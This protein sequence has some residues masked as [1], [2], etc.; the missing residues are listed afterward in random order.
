MTLAAIVRQSRDKLIAGDILVSNFNNAPTAAASGGEQGTG[1]PATTT[2]GTVVRLALDLDGRVPRLVSS[3]VIADGLS[4]HTDPAALIVGPTGLALDH[5]GDL[6]VADTVNSRIAV[7]PDAPFRRTPINAGADRA[8]VSHDPALNG[9][10]GLAIAPDGHLLAVNG[11]DNNVVELSRS[12]TAVT[13]RDLDPV[14]PPGGWCCP[15][16]A[17]RSA[18]RLFELWQVGCYGQVAHA[19]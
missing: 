10:L 13:V 2:N 14:D 19:K 9:P 17:G 7:I 1:R 11:A 3:T 4:V 15:P 12:G 6:F 5:D 8:T 16:A 18:E